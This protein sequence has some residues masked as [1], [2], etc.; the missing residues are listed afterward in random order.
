MRSAL[1]AICV[2]LAFTEGCGYVG[3][4]S[5]PSPE[6][7]VPVANLTAVER[8]NQIEVSFTTPGLTT[9]LLQVKKFS[10]IELRAG[11]AVTP[12]NVSKWEASSKQYEFPSLPTIDADDPQP[13]PLKLN[14]PVS[15][16]QGQRITVAV[17][18]AVKSGNRFSLWSAP[19]NL[20]VIEPLQAPKVS[21]EATRDGYKL[22]WAEERPEVQYEVLRSGPG[23]AAASSVGT[24][25]KP[26]FVD[27]TS[28]WDVPYTYFVLAKKDGAES[29]RSQGVSVNYPDKFAPS[30][31]QGVTALAGPDSVELTWSRSPEADLKGYRIY[32]AVGNGPLEPLGELINLPTFSDRK[33]EH[34]KTYRY[35][36]SAVDLKNNESEK[37]SAVEV[38]F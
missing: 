4:V 27:S 3:P 26:S 5:P 35:A 2:V 32:R 22:T 15:D 16:W 10:A 19:V 12:F 11:P 17:R 7:P 37:S 24:A 28:Q 29:P 34:G 23:Q 14:I 21:A 25:D 31:P 38:S 20:D 6:I 9:D 13:V 33:V 30:V 1:F 36:I 8:G 18:T